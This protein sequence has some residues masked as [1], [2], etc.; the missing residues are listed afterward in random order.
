MS[1]L[2]PLHQ[3]LVN[4]YHAVCAEVPRHLRRSLIL[5]GGAASIVHGMPDRKTD[6]ADITVSTESLA[7]LEDAAAN[8]RG[9]FHRD[10]DGAIK[11]NE[12]DHLGRFSFSVDIEYVLLGGPFVPRAPEVVGF[13]DWFVATF[14]ELLWLRAVTLV[15]RG[16]D[17]DYTDFR[18]IL[19]MMCQRGLKLSHIEKEELE[20][21]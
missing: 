3:A 10:T 12:R 6:D 19:P 13:G 20:T 8:K 1:S 17:S 15:T 21:W 14:P 5:I 9:G 18:L 4:A 7:F 11:W 2:S 16:K